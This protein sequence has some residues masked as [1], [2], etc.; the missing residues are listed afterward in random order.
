MKNKYPILSLASLAIVTSCQDGK[1]NKKDTNE[2]P[3]NIIFIVSED[4]SPFL[5]CYGDPNANT[6]NLD[7]LAEEGILYENAFAGD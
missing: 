1:N 7:K 3:P 2:T 4:N 5:G 6:P